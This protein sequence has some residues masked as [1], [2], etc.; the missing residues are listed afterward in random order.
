MVTI[1]KGEIKG[2][3]ADA[4]YSVYPQQILGKLHAGIQEH[5]VE[6]LQLGNGFPSDGIK[7]DMLG[8]WRRS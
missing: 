2:L 8:S 6:K 5:L 1:A 7:T 4:V 3:I